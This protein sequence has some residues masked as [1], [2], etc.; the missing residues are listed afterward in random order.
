MPELDD[1][2]QE[3]PEG[4]ENLLKTRGFP[5]YKLRGSLSDYVDIVCNL[6][7]IPVYKNK[8]QS[9]HVLFSLYAAVKNSQLYKATSNEEENLELQEK[10]ND[11][12]QL[13]LE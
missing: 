9:L 8:I 11:A 12:D 13:V 6:F 3:W 5:S 2:M 10:S 4:M 1:L 7:D